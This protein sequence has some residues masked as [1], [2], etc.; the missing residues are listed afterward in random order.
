MTN[1]YCPPDKELQLHTLLVNHNVFITGD[2]NGHSP[3]WRYADLNSRGEQI[4][5]WMIVNSL[6]LISRPKDQPTHLSCAW[7]TLSTPDLAI[8]SEDI[9]KICVKEVYTQLGGSNHLPVLLKMTGS[10]ENDNDRTDHLSEEETQLELQKDRLVQVPKPDW[11]A[12]QRTW[13]WKQQQHQHQCPAAD[14]LHTSGSK[15]GHPQRQEKGLQVLLEQPPP[16]SPWSTHRSQKTIWAAAFHQ[17]TPSSTTRQG[18][19]LMKKRSR[20]PACHGKKRLVHSTWRMTHRS[21]RIW[22]RPRMMTSNMPQEQS[23]W[24][25]VPRSSQARMQSACLQTGSERIA[26]LMSQG[27]NKQTSEWRLRN[28]YRNNLQPP[29]WHL[30]SPSMSGTIPSDS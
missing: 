2:F 27:R 13:H 22:Q 25:K 30:S 18:L 16:V 12:V 24:R 21:S 15:A 4:E 3:S 7:K 6:I 20:K 29:A 19:L 1:Y 23:F 8:T 10:T 26:Y 11:H 9:Q 5:D 17:S 28:N 14:W